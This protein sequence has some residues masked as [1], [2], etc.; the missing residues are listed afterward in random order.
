MLISKGWLLHKRRAKPGAKENCSILVLLKVQAQD[1][2]KNEV[3]RAKTRAL[4]SL[5]FSEIE[6]S[7][8]DK[9]YLG[10]THMQIPK[11]CNPILE[12]LME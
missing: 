12:I 4:I 9:N 2:L 10:S 3:H 1:W 11:Y 8:F 6:F 5:Q 7:L